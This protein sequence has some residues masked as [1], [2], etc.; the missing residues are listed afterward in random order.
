MR[1][2]LV[3]NN[4]IKLYTLNLIEKYYV[5]AS[6]NIRRMKLDVGS[7]QHALRDNGWYTPQDI[8]NLSNQV[9][10]WQ[11]KIAQIQSSG[12]SRLTKYRVRN[13]GE[14]L[15]KEK[16]DKRLN[17]ID[18]NSRE[19]QVIVEK[20]LPYKKLIEYVHNKS[21]FTKNGFYAHRGLFECQSCD[22]K[23]QGYIITQHDNDNEDEY[24]LITSFCYNC[25]FK[26]YLKT[27]DRRINNMIATARKGLRE[28]RAQ[29]RQR[30]GGMQEL[31]I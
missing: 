4:M 11:Q 27:K 14:H 8:Q 16:L 3:R 10:E 30:G 2:Q 22:E 5:D 12:V 9:I 7:Y 23:T 15:T 31:R 19:I 1:R 25:G 17:E 26:Y 6:E 21:V 13:I 20:E 24:R 29:V 18:I 28:T